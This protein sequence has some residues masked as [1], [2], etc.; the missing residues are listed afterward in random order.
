VIDPIKITGSLLGLILL[1]AV[2][3]RCLACA[4][5]VQPAPVDAAGWQEVKVPSTFDASVR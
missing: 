2:A 5:Q 3:A 4:P 1:G